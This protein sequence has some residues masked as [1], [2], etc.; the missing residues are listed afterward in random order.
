MMRIQSKIR[1]VF[2]AFAM[3]LPLATLAE[4]ADKDA[5]LN[6][7]ADFAR[8]DELRQTTNLKGNVVISKGTIRIRAA[9]VNVKLDQDGYEIATATADPGKR[10]FF[11]QKREGLDEFIEAEAETMEYN[12]RADTVQFTRNAVMRRYR[13]VVLFDEVS[14]SSIF[15]DNKTES[16]SVD[17]PP[18]GAASAA[19]V[20][21]GQGRVRMVLT[22]RPAASAVSA[23]QPSAPAPLRPSSAIG[24]GR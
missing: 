19:S 8:R 2:I 11:R 7:E 17:N 10:V 9:V 13:G 5:A 22:P 12:S 23:P 14:G 16:F 21:P 24:A 18:Q 4:R 3:V 20:A 1:A 6:A 15:Y